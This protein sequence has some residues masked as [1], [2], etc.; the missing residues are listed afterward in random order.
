MGSNPGEAQG[1][2]LQ[3]E[4]AELPLADSGSYDEITAN[5]KGEKCVL[6]NKGDG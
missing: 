5:E 3:L 2:T 6:S 4:L 1:D